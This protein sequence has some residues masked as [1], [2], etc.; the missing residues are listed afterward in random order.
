[1][2]RQKYKRSIREGERERSTRKKKEI[3]RE[4]N[5]I[6]VVLCCVRN[7]TKRKRSKLFYHLVVD[8][9]NSISVSALGAVGSLFC[10]LS[11][12]LG[13]FLSSE[14]FV[15]SSFSYSN[16]PFCLQ[17]VG[18]LLSILCATLKSKVIL[19]CCV[20]TKLKSPLLPTRIKNFF[21]KTNNP[22]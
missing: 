5:T 21:P 13:F 6:K 8:V 18:G 7:K 11:V 16:Q 9:H 2:R 19:V 14:F 4:V 17:K 22:F 15:F 3:L 1:M 20:S 10:F 12:G